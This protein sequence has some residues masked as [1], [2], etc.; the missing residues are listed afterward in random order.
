MSKQQ[1]EDNVNAARTE[2][3]G[4]AGPSGNAEAADA[5]AGAAAGPQG[6]NAPGASGPAAM[7]TAPSSTPASA[8]AGAGAGS[9]AAAAG[10]NV[11]EAD[12]QQLVGLGFSREMAEGAL[13]A[14]NGNVDQ[15]ASMLF[16]M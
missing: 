1:A 14:A 15:A 7:D 8:N 3:S 6:T 2:S 9:G 11:N 16:G 13:R 12:V 10:S 4:G 5:G